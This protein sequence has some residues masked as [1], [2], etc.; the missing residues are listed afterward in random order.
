MSIPRCW[1]PPDTA[2]RW[3]GDRAMCERAR[4]FA[5]LAGATPTKLERSR[6]VLPAPARGVRAAAGLSGR[7]VPRTPSGRQHRRECLQSP[8]TD[9]PSAVSRSMRRPAPLPGWR[10]RW[11]EDWHEVCLD[12]FHDAITGTSIRRVFDEHGPRLEAIAARATRRPSGIWAPAAGKPAVS[13]HHRWRAPSWSR[14]LPT[15]R[16]HCRDRRR[17]TGG[18]RRGVCSRSPVHLLG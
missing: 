16:Q 8:H 6:G 7:I 2:M 17:Q 13:I 14:F 18:R 10:W 11:D 15:P 12:Q 5:D 3:R 1:S 9:A 4:R